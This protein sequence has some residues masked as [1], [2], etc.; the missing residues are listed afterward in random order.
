M[1]AARLFS[2]QCSI[3][4]RLS[5]PSAVFLRAGRQLITCF[6][7]VE[8]SPRVLPRFSSASS[9][10]RLRWLK[11]FDLLAIDM[12][13]LEAALLVRSGSRIR[14]LQLAGEPARYAAPISSCA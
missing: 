2:F 10:I 11:R 4:T 7:S 13:Q 9:I 6:S 5:C 3:S 1:P 14:E 12:R 8:A